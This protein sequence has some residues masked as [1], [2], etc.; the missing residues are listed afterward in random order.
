M[1]IA[2]ARIWLVLSDDINTEGTTYMDGWN[3]NEYLF[4]YKLIN[5]PEN[6]AE[7]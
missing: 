4:E 2:R 5:Q 1:L 7:P 6:E 3:P